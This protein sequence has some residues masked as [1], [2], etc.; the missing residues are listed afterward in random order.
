M[1][2]ATYAA[3]LFLSLSSTACT[4]GSSSPTGPSTRPTIDVLPP[5][6]GDAT[7]TLTGRITE[8]APA[9]P[10]GIDGASVTIADG[11]NAGRS[12]T[13]DL[14]GYYT[15][16]S[17]KPSSFTLA[18]SATGYVTASEKIDLAFDRTTNLELRPEPTRLTYTLRGDIDS[19]DGSCHDG[20]ASRPC[21][22]ITFPVHNPG[23]IEA[24]LTWT[25]EAEPDDADLDLSLFQTG[26][27]QP[28]AR[29]AVRGDVPEQL[30][31]Q[32]TIPSI[33]ELRITFA[34][35]RG[36]ASY[37]IAYSQPN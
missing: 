22:I 20:V 31:T 24:R 29:S 13:T 21:R 27:T 18:V 34:A 30:A 19:S 2:R 16:A 3:L 36:A 23:P 15:L 33:Y 5:A 25:S 37:T 11:V 35:G 14:T 6:P 32:V 17:L 4:E 1:L 9:K 28:I 8:S 26:A 10:G 12:T 7:F